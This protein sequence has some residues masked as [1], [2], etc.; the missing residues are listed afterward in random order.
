MLP[1]NNGFARRNLSLASSF[2]NVVRIACGIIAV[3]SLT[4]LLFFAIAAFIQYKFFGITVLSFVIFAGNDNFIIP[5]AVRF[6]VA[7]SITS[8]PFRN[9]FQVLLSR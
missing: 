3:V 1:A 9:G 4:A 6:F 7:S 2:V 8:N 5:D